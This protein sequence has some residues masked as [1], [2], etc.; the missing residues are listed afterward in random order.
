MR[1]PAATRDTNTAGITLI[2]TDLD[3]VLAKLLRG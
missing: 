3:M 1:S 2:S